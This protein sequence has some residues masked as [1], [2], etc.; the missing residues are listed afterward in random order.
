MRMQKVRNSIMAMAIVALA[1]LPVEGSAYNVYYRAN[2]SSPWVFYAG[3]TTSAAANATVVDLQATGYSAQVVSG[4]IAP[5]G[6]AGVIG[7][8]VVRTGPTVTP[9]G[10][11]GS[12]SYF[13]TWGGSPGYSYGGGASYGGGGF[14]NADNWHHHD[15]SQDGHHRSGGGLHHHPTAHPHQHAAAS[16]AHHASAHHA[17]HHGAH[18]GHSHS[19]S[20]SHSHHGK[21]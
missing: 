13:N 8:T 2:P 12:S 4:V 16:H 18:H 1:C 11:G 20:H 3:R 10:T 15:H 9:Y 6:A 21:K 19:H 14:R 5:N 7:P 17:A